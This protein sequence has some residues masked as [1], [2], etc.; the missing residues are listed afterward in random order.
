[1][2]GTVGEEYECEIEICGKPSFVVLDQ[3]VI[4]VITK[5]SYDTTKKKTDQVGKH[6]YEMPNRIISSKTSTTKY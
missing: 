4:F 2:L 1:M 6:L 3:A 5:L